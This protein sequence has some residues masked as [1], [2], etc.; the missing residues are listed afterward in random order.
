MIDLHSHILHGLDDGARSLDE[1][2]AMARLA[3]ADGITV[4]AAT[5]HSPASTASIVYEPA[6]VRARAARLAS[7]L[8][9][10]GIALQVVVGTEVSFEPAMAEKLDRG[11]L[12]TYA[13]SRTVLLEPPWGQLPANFATALFSLQIAGYRVLLAHPERLPD[14]QDDP[15]L[16][17]PLIERGMLVQLTAQALAGGQ[18]D[19]MRA[20]AEMLLT[21]N[22]VHVLA[23]DAHG[24]AP[25]RTPSLAYAR[26]RAA[27]LLGEV[28]ASALVLDTPR[29]LLEGL[30]VTPPPPRPVAKRPRRR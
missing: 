22:L 5:P 29:A 17:I 27:D 20:V 1:S 24:P 14:V 2:L 28:A 4:M 19:H 6:V 21:H 3:V 23:S 7:A 18:G 12:L 10:E 25:R 13:G 26:R 30:P 8:A 16:L 11:E 15:N 9:A